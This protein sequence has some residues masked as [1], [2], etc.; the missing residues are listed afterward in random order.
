MKRTTVGQRHAVHSASAARTAD[1]I[2]IKKSKISAAAGG[3]FTTVAIARGTCVGFYEGVGTRARE[4]DS[5]DFDASFWFS[6]GNKDAKD[7]EGRLRLS[8]SG[9][10]L[11]V[12]AFTN[13]DW[14]TLEAKEEWGVWEGVDSNWT[15]FMNH[16]SA[17]YQ[18]ISVSMDRERFGK[19]LAFYA[20]RHIEGEEE[21]F[22]S[23]G[24]KAYFEHLGFE[25]EDP[26]IC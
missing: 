20:K 1:N 14:V 16:A 6:T 8:S 22:F 10:L 24:N 5:G 19:S 25:P 21:L 15:R 9:A 13:N 2:I 3:A 26:Q 11:N 12:H 7:F 4:R 17:D 23:Y 18:N